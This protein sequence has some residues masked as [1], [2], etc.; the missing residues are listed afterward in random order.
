MKMKFLVVAL[1]LLPM[2]ARAEGEA[3]IPLTPAVVNITDKPSLQ[4]GARLFANYCL[5]CHSLK[6]MR[7]NMV[8]RDIGLTNKEMADN[9][10]FASP[11]VVDLMTVAMT[12]AEGKRWFGVSP[13]DLS[14]IAR[15]R[16][17]DWLV[18]YLMGFYR[19]PSR[20]TGVN[21]V[22][23]PNVAMPDVLW[24]LH[25]VQE[26]VY[27][28][29][30]TS[31]GAEHKTLVGLKQVRPGE[32]SPGQYRRAVNDLVNFLV[33][34]GEPAAL[35]R[36]ALGPWVLAFILVFFLIARLLYKEYWKDVH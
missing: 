30:E 24:S 10:M 26:P 8:A 29:T 20:P 23:F 18:S 14:D 27:K 35:Q 6:Y 32:M 5:S 28:I 22:V 15:A 16:G 33:L 11:K 21:N 9:L 4:R 25:G 17:A 13:P 19:D 1:C 31:T 7:Y 2:F 34:M 36:E 3:G 12:P